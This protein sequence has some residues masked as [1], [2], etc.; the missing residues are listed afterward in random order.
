MIFSDPKYHSLRGPGLQARKAPSRQSSIMSLPNE[1]VKELI[2]RSEPVAASH[3]SRE[4]SS[5]DRAV[6][7]IAV[8]DRKLLG[9]SKAFAGWL[10]LNFAV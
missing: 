6:M 10:V 3:S 7:A 4:E 2:V 8:E 1:T 9:S 5:D